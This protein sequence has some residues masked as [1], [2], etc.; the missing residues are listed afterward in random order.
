MAEEAGA[1]AKRRIRPYE[2]EELELRW[3]A[4]W[5]A[6]GLYRAGEDPSRP[7]FYCLDFFPYPSGDGLSVGHGRNDVPTDVISRD[8]R[9]AAMNVLHPMG[10]RS[11]SGGRRWSRRPA[12]GPPG[13]S[14]GEGMA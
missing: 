4:A 7:K 6:A 12:C 9:M 5:D 13:E 10:C 1:Q 2:P 3:R 11:L 14:R 8:K